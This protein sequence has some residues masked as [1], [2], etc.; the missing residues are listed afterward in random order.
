MICT[1][2]KSINSSI[3]CLVENN[4]SVKKRFGRTFKC[5]PVDINYYDILHTCSSEREAFENEYAFTKENEQEAYNRYK[6]LNKGFITFSLEERLDCSDFLKRFELVYSDADDFK[7]ISLINHCDRFINILRKDYRH[8]N[9][10]GVGRKG[11]KYL[12]FHSYACK[13][14][15][16]GELFERATTQLSVPVSVDDKEH[17]ISKYAVNLFDEYLTVVIDWSESP[18]FTDYTRHIQYGVISRPAK[19]EIEIFNVDQTIELFHEWMQKSNKITD[20]W[21]GVLYDDGTI[22]FK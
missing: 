10:Y 21:N 8:M 16:F 7:G 6:D 2:E 13:I 1:L 3:A 9:F 12:A 17:S 15:C 14:P 18:M 5:S 19:K 11:N 20:E 4:N 22:N